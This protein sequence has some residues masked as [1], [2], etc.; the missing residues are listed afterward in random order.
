[1]AGSA[2]TVLPSREMNSGRRISHASVCTSSL[3]DPGYLGAGRAWAW[4]RNTF[5]VLLQPGERQHPLRDAEI[6]FG[7]EVS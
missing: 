6:V 1:V 2:T 7:G 3:R 5:D 4:G